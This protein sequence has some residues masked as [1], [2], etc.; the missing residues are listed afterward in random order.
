MSVKKG[1]TIADALKNPST[2]GWASSAYKFW[3]TVTN[4]DQLGGVPA[5]DFISLLEGDF[6]QN[7]KFG[8]G[9]FILGNRDNFRIKV[10][11]TDELIIENSLGEEI[12]L[13]IGSNPS[14]NVIVVNTT[15]I[16]PSDTNIFSLG[17]VNAKWKDIFVTDVKAT[18]IT[19]TLTGNST[20]VHKGNVI[21]GS[22]GII[23]NSATNE[24][25]NPDG[26]TEFRGIFLG[27]FGSLDEPAT[28]FGTATNA[29]TLAGILP[30]EQ[31]PSS[32]TK[33]TVAVRDTN[34]DIHARNFVASGSVNKASTLAFDSGFYSASSIIPGGVDKRS[35]VARDTAGDIYAT[36]FRGTATA[37]RYADL[38]EKYLADKDYEVGTVLA[39]GGEKEVTASQSGDRAIGV[40]SANPAY[41]MNSEL[42]GGTYV[43][44]KGRVPVKV[45]GEIKKK[46]R[47]VASNDGY[48]VKSESHQ[49]ADVFAIALEDG[50]ELIEA[51]IL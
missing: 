32:G 17:N 49:Y 15:G 14:S 20:G 25:G 6:S 46:D 40:V 16:I 4:A 41:M 3:G 48:A 35:I 10:E 19:G 24:V 5:A 38:A 13:R 28:V 36:L 51:V 26:S 21:S 30:S 18:N 47:L 2:G 37:A 31:V 23:V 29:N 27:S 42:E 50:V 9:G 12:T 34:G 39:V 1:I 11:N 33:V 45:R 22:D 8:D 43:A 7:I 44:L